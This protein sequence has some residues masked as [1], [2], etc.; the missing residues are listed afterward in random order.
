MEKQLAKVRDK[1]ST[2]NQGKL[3]PLPPAFRRGPDRESR[4]LDFR[5]GFEPLASNS[6]LVRQKWRKL[7]LRVWSALKGEWCMQKQGAK[8]SD[9]CSTQNQGSRLPIL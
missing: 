8:G 7:K 3:K 2:H 9:K 6:K 1:C 4:F 5:W